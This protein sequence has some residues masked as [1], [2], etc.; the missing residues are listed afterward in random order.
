MRRIL[1]IALWSIILLLVASVG[2]AQDFSRRFT[3]GLSGS[4]WKPGLSEHSDIYTVGKSG[5]LFFEYDLKEK[6][7]LGFSAAYARAWEADLSERE[8]GGAGFTFS[9]LEDGNRLTHVW[10]DVCLIHNFRPWERLN[11]YVFSGLG[12]AWW[13]VKDKDGNYVQELDLSGEPFDLR[14]QELT[15]SGGAGVEYRFR[16]RYGFDFGTR[17]RILSRILS[18]FEGSKD[19][20]GSAPGELDLPKGT[21]EIFF[22]VRCYLGKLMDSDKDGVPDRADFCSDT[23]LGALV[24]ERGCPLDSDNDG[25]YDGLDR[26]PATPPGTSVDV[27]GCP[28]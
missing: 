11:P 18:S 8:G 17:F 9:R 16:E 24:D 20:V 27:H 25:I 6:I 10:L 23:P 15:F 22:G 19:I 5:S 7:S 3:L 28:R 1:S 4:L 21:L 2:N 14:D 26:C 12:L 13:S